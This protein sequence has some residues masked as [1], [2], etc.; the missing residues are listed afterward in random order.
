M[1]YLP[2]SHESFDMAS[3][4]IPRND[5]SIAGSEMYTQHDDLSFLDLASS[6]VDDFGASMTA[7][8]T[9]TQH[10]NFATHYLSN[11][12]AGHFENSMT[13]SEMYTQH[14]NLVTPGRLNC[15]IDN[16]YKNPQPGKTYLIFEKASGKALHIFDN[17]L[18]LAYNYPS[19]NPGLGLNWLC[20]Q[21]GSCIGFFNEE[22]GMYV[23]YNNEE[24]VPVKNFD[25]HGHF[26]PKLHIDGGYQLVTR[27]ADP[28]REVAVSC[29]NTRLVIRQHGGACFNFVEMGRLR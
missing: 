5:D 25:F 12:Q 2:D 27:A 17:E 23:G 20:V 28:N 4:Y 22:T 9:Y 19:D 26:I 21:A 24:V 11:Y 15:Q 1:S 3:G 16:I 7:S 10:N 13:A 14:N 18:F 6:Q 8:E 29:S